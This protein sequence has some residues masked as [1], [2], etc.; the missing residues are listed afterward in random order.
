MLELTLV[1][2]EQSALTG[3]MKVASWWACTGFDGMLRDRW[4][5]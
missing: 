3:A 2:V 1:E 5:Q 4:R